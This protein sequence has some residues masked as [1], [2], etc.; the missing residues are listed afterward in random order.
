MVKADILVLLL[1][2]RLLTTVSISLIDI[3]LFGLSVS[4]FMRFGSLYILRKFSMLSIVNCQL[5]GIKLSMVF[6]YYPFDI[7]R[8]CINV[9]SLIFDI[10]NLHILSFFL[11]SLS[12]SLLNF[13]IFS[14]NKIFGSLFCCIVFLL[15]TSFIFC[16][17]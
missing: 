15:Y 5:I 11:I 3:G 14:E 17:E 8:T 7:F 4:T 16:S 2:G 12:R 10:G 9:T 13:F 6:P 1:M